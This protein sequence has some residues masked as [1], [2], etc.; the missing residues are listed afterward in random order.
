MSNRSGGNRQI[1]IVD[2]VT[3]LLLVMVVALRISTNSAEGTPGVKDA[4]SLRFSSMSEATHRED[5]TFGVALI[6]KDLNPIIG[7]PTGVLDDPDEVKVVQIYSV[8]QCAYIDVFQS[9]DDI[10]QRDLRVVVFARDRGTLEKGTLSVQVE[11]F[12]RRDG[13]GWRT[14][15]YASTEGDRMSISQ[16]DD[17][18]LAFETA[19]AEISLSDLVQS[20]NF[21][22]LPVGERD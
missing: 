16:F 18:Q 20:D 11:Y 22:W 1:F 13:G 15:S 7:K 5:P 2:L 19:I 21:N 3:L 14:L 6:G 8:P 9:R 12:D 10:L 4:V 17:G